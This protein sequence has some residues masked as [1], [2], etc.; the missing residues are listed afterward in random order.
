MTWWVA[1]RRPACA[2][3]LPAV[4]LAIVT[5]LGGIPR[6][7]FDTPVGI[8]STCTP[9]NACSTLPLEISC[10]AIERTV[11]LGIAKPT[12]TLALTVPPSIWAL[13]PTTW[14]AASSSGPPELPW[15]IG[16]SVWIEFGIVRPFGAWMSRPIADTIPAVIV[17]SSPNG[18][19]IA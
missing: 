10:W 19:P 7:I 6:T 13:T 14:P 11:S 8:V 1:A 12:P 5:P 2:A 3:G 9:M 4:T 15:L 16:A 18:L 17:R